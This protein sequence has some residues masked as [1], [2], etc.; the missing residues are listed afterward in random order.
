MN[1]SDLETRT[2]LDLLEWFAKDD[3][4]RPLLELP[5]SSEV[6][7]MLDDADLESDYDAEVAYVDPAKMAKYLL[8]RLKEEPEGSSYE[9][10]DGPYCSCDGCGAKEVPL[11]KGYDFDDQWRCELCDKT[12]SI[13]NIKGQNVNASLNVAIEIITRRL[14]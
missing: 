9:L 8:Q 4:R 2:L 10:R 11:R 5:A 1:L 6:R 7:E 14:R 13:D 12:K 3:V